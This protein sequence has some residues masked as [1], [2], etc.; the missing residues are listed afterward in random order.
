MELILWRHAEA[1]DAG[2]KGDLARELTKH[3]RKQARQMAEWL[4]PRLEGEWRVVASPAARTLQTVDA[5]GLD[6]E[7]S[8]AIAPGTSP[9]AL[10]HEAG[11]PTAAR[12]VIVVGHQPTLGEVAAEL[13]HSGDG[14]VA[15]RK[16]AV[17]WFSTRERGGALETVLKAVVDPDIAAG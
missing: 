16:G 15:M 17:W 9:R 2:A 6:F 5:L 10:L 8:D 1:E 12:N 14:D 11:W 13:L 4:K 3:G 7:V